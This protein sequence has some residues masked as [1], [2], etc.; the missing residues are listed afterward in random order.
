[1]SAPKDAATAFG[2][3]LGHE[4]VE[5]CGLFCLS[6]RHQVL[7][8]HELSRGTVDRSSLHP[9]EVF[10]AAL[11]ANAVAV[12]IGHNHPSG[13]PSP[14]AD[15]V[16]LT[17]RIKSAGDLIGIELLDHVVVASDRYVSFKDRNWM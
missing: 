8:Y 10:K 6:A 9:R 4:A 15:D 12:I 1:L 13:D 5:V 11:L 16:R 17:H 3:I 2:R 7:A 14:S